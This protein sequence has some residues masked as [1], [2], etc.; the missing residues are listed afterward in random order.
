MDECKEKGPLV[1]EAGVQN[2]VTWSQVFTAL[3][4]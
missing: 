1:E 3:A 2:K 4:L